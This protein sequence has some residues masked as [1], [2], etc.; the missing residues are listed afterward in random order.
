MQDQNMLEAL[1][2]ARR[3]ATR[4]PISLELRWREQK[5]KI[6]QGGRETRINDYQLQEQYRALLEQVADF[7]RSIGVLVKEYKYGLQDASGQI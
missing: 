3:K 7:W 4:T 5:R 6:T 1:S 2:L